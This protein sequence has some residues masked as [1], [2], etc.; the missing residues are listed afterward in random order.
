MQQMES[1]NGYS[2]C[3]CLKHPFQN[4][5]GVSQEQ[6]VMEELLESNAKIDAKKMAD[7]LDYF[8]QLSRHINYY[9]SN[10]FVSDWTGFFEKSVPFALA[11][12]IRYNSKQFTENFE[13]YKSFFKKKSTPGGLQLAQHFIFYN[14]LKRIQVWYQKIKGTE[15]PVE[16]VF[17]SI[18]RDKLR[19]PLADLAGLNRLA[20]KWFSI[21]PIDFSPFM[22]DEIWGLESAAQVIYQ[23]H[24]KEDE[25]KSTLHC[26]LL[27]ETY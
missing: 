26:D 2:L 24:R 3:D 5:P 1:V 16:R 11:A 8:S 23:V 6:R 15:L 4:D 22:A 20:A 25:F 27:Q 17:E 21:T 7:L 12:V 19:Q 10:L 14:S 13:L 9:D 18:I